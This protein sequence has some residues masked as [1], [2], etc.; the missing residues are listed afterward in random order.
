MTVQKSLISA[1]VA[2]F[3]CG[4]SCYAAVIDVTAYSASGNDS[5]DDTASIQNAIAALSDGDT[6]LF[7]YCTNHY[8]YRLDYY[9]TQQ[10]AGLAITEN[11]ITIIIQGR[12]K[13]SGDPRDFN[14]IFY[15]QSAQDLTIIGQGAEGIIEGSGQ[16]NYSPSG[17]DGP[18]LIRSLAAQRLTI[19]KLILI[20]GPTTSVFLRGCQKT[21]ITDCLFKGG[22]PTMIGTNVHGI[23]YTGEQE[24]HIEGNLF[25]PNETGGKAYS[26]ISSG[27]T[28]SSYHASFINNKF[29]ASFDHSIYTSGLFKS[30]IAN[31]ICYNST[32]TAIKTIGSENVIVNNN[33]YNDNPPAVLGAISS[34]NGARNIIANNQI[35]NYSH[36]AISVSLY[37]GGWG[38]IYTDNTIEGN[39]IVGG[40]EFS[41]HWP[42]E[43]IRVWGTD[44]SGTKIMNNIIIGADTHGAA[45]SG[46]IWLYSPSA[47]SY[48][49][50]VS[51]NIFDGSAGNGITLYNV[52]NSLFSDNT[53]NIPTGKID[54]NEQGG[55]ANNMY[56]DNL[57]SYH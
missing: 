53:I 51:G 31:N 36:V 29:N 9:R 50:T 28:A 25:K 14:E 15:I 22:P 34:R 55:S 44:I 32:G 45:G 7:P 27:S 39:Y 16:F 33:I 49:L 47:P 17:Y 8:L 3:L 54:F 41:G 18:T 30:V 11:G 19:K 26:W 35:V 57:V 20:D 13:G 23:A 4:I 48:N 43:A 56:R 6:L 46:V 1:L 2:L 42:Y 5:F 10:D 40:P 52:H 38:G 12:I 37:G 21:H 24:L